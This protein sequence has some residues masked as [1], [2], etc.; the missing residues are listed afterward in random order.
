ME[1]ITIAPDICLTPGEGYFPQL[2][3]LVAREKSIVRYLKA[4]CSNPLSTAQNALN[5]IT[6][7]FYL[8]WV[9]DH[10]IGC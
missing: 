8:N 7:L 2:K 1:G 3:P 10:W 5:R 4:A 6:K 9:Y